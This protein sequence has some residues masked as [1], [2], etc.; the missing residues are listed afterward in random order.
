[1]PATQHFK[2]KKSNIIMGNVIHK[3]ETAPYREQT[4]SRKRTFRGFSNVF[5]CHT[6]STNKKI[7]K[8]D[9]GI[10]FTWKRS[11]TPFSKGSSKSL[12][13]SQ[14]ETRKKRKENAALPFARKRTSRML[15]SAPSSPKSKHYIRVGK[16]VEERNRVIP[17]AQKSSILKRYKVDPKEIAAGWNAVRICVDRKTKE[18]FVVKTISKSIEDNIKRIEREV[19]I[20]RSLDHPNIISLAETYED[21]DLVHLITP[22]CRGGSLSER[23]YKREMD[24]EA[25]SELE[26]F[27]IAAQILSAI[28]LCHKKGIAHRDIKPENFVFESNDQNAKLKLIDFGLSKF[29]Q[30]SEKDWK[31]GHTCVGSVL[32][33]A[34][35][36]LRGIWYGTK[37]DLWS[38]GIIFY[39]LC[40]GKPPFDGYTEEEIFYQILHHNMRLMK[41]SWRGANKELQ[42]I[43]FSL[44]SSDELSRPSA[45]EILRSAC[46]CHHD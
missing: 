27:D 19:N 6:K 36:V 32:Y 10:Q 18:E 39:T 5:I 12:T 8:G 11:S 29:M 17:F 2:S 33:I 16:N 4:I 26:I 30:D 20:L 28:E 14:Q 13:K 45:S 34:P 43:I 23:M 25:F 41:H 46:F 1:M 3:S 7:K 38:A 31:S 42:D 15:S 24:G 22:F 37:C 44:L 9:N 40:C 21:N 35:E